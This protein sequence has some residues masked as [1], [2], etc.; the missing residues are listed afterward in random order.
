MMI[1]ESVAVFKR[2]SRAYTLLLE[3]RSLAKLSLAGNLGAK[4]QS[5]KYFMK[6]LELRR[7]TRFSPNVLSEYD[8][9]VSA[10]RPKAHLQHGY[11]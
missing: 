11:R 4:V 2:V 5:L 6:I 7:K 3:S 10:E 1:E 8:T 9:E